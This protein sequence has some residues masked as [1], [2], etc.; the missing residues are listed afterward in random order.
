MRFLI[1]HIYLQDEIIV[2]IAVFI[3]GPILT[4]LLCVVFPNAWCSE[5]CCVRRWTYFWD[6]FMCII[7]PFFCYVC[8][9]RECPPILP[10]EMRQGTDWRNGRWSCCPDPSPGVQGRPR[11]CFN[12]TYFLLQ[13][14][15]YCCPGQTNLLYADAAEAQSLTGEYHSNP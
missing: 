11:R 10:C 8:Q 13:Y 1:S 5:Y 2:F 12:V 4:Y 3:A 14:F 7:C 9:G 6:R 15:C